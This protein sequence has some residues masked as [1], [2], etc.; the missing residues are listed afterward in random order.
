M[1]EALPWGGGGEGSL[2]FV[3]EPHAVNRRDAWTPGM[4][5]ARNSGILFWP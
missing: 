4:A 1:A 3:P 5:K 2:L